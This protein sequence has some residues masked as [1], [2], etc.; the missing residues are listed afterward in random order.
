MERPKLSEASTMRA[1]ISTCLTGMSSL[2]IRSCTCS[3]LAGTSLTNTWL[4]RTSDST[5]PRADKMRVAAA[6]PAAGMLPVRLRATSA[7][8]A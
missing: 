3:S 6:A 2:R 7:A 1:S 8:R 5:L 4:V